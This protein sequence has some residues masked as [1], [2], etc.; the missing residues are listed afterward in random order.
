MLRYDAAPVM[1][2]QGRKTKVHSMD[3]PSF[4]DEAM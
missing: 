1:W 2:M 4:S 3:I